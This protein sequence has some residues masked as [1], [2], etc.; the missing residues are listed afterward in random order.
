MRA[1]ASEVWS[2]AVIDELTGHHAFIEQD[3]PSTAQ[4]L[5]LHI[6]QN[7]ET[8]LSDSPEPGRPAGRENS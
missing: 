7:A 8:F 4:R 5:A 3:D 2:I 1:N 6:L